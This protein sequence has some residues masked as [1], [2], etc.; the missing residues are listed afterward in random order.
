MF[1]PKKLEAFLDALE[2]ET[3]YP[4]KAPTL[5]RHGAYKPVGNPALEKKMDKYDI[6]NQDGYQNVGTAEFPVLAREGFSL[7]ITLQALHNMY[8]QSM[9]PMYSYGSGTM[10]PF[11]VDADEA[12]AAPAPSPY[13]NL[14]GT[15]RQLKAV[16]PAKLANPAP[17]VPQKS[18]DYIGTLT[19]WRGWEVTDGLLESL[20]TDVTW[21]PKVAPKSQCRRAKTSHH[22]GPQKN[23]TCGY[24]SFKSLEL[25][26]QSLCGY[27]NTVVIGTV[28]IWGRVIECTNGYRSE[29]AY[30]KELWLLKDGLESLSWT[31]GVPVRTL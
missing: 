24:W 25:L 19:G 3:H 26:T 14:K 10:A 5:P 29:F 21:E 17:P 28:E 9:W 11:W 13:E 15:V 8:S 6:F 22:Y 4:S 7:G 16:T 31:Y 1:D 27:K 2:V 18:P 23:C 20:G 30:P 12:S